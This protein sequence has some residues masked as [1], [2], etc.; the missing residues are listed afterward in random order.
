MKMKIKFP[1]VLILIG[2]FVLT[3]V[4]IADSNIQ[5]NNIA[6][7][8]TIQK[9]AFVSKRD[10]NSE[11]YT[12]NEDG[13]DLNRLTKNKAD[14][15]MPQWSPDGT[16]L[17]YLSKKSG[18]YEIWTINGDGSGQLKLANECSADYPP[19]WSPDGSK[20]LFIAKNRG[21]NAIFV[22]NS[23]GSGLVRIS[24]NGLEGS[25]P[26]W[27][28]DGSKILFL[29]RVKDD[30]N[31]YLMNPDGTGRQKVTRESGVCASP[32]WSP[33][34]WR[35]AYIF[36]KQA[37][38]AN[39]NKLYVMNT[40]GS[41]GVIVADVSK[42][43]EDIVFNDDFCWSPDGKNIAFTKVA[44]V[45]GNVSDNGRVTYTFFYGTYIVGSDGNSNEEQLAV[46]G[47]ERAYPAWSPD[48]SK[49]A[50]LTSSQLNI[51]TVKSGTASNIR[52]GASIPLS[53]P[54]WSPDG[55][56]I[57]FVAKNSSFQKSGIYLVDLDEKVIKLTESGDYDPVWA[58][59][60]PLK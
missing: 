40:D 25:A 36:N 35:I 54:R 11:I 2:L 46:T 33:D 22:I 13:K 52:V 19:S 55:K 53:S 30:T 48:S 29:Q 26:S 43:V 51:Y 41:N 6:V 49:V 18:K 59:A 39:E 38:I 50:Y 21:K 17:L 31:I 23:D 32:A 57:I 1:L 20:I 10:G 47:E 4:I 5:G 3:P 14:D 37:F 58:P 27:S 15:L 9:I 42:K 24:E 7:S 44:K 60:K 45:E 8:S 34:G 16:R 12:I 56:K 28:P